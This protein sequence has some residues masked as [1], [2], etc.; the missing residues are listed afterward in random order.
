MDI[1]TNQINQGFL[2]VA[3]KEA[4]KRAS[5]SI[6]QHLTASYSILQHLTASYSILQHLTASYS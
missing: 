5:Y 6:L 3:F 1:D 2:N 4:L